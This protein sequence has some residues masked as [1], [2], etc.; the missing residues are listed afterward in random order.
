MILVVAVFATLLLREER[1][2]RRTEFDLRVNVTSTAI[3]LAVEHAPRSGTLGEV[4]RLA[5]DLV[6]KQ[7]EIVRIRLLDSQLGPRV[8]ANLLTADAGVPLRWHQQ[9]RTSGQPAV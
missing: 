6:V 5:N 1:G 7:T 9:V 3:R 2:Q 8:D 4:K